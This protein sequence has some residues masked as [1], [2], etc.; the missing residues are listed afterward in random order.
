MVE[1]LPRRL[2]GLNRAVHYLGAFGHIKLWGVAFER[3]TACRGYGASRDE[4]ARAWN[5]ALFNG[6]LD[7]DIA[8]TSALGFDVAQCGEALFQ[9]TPGG[10]GGPCGAQCER[11][12]QNV[13]IVPALRGILALQEDVRVRIDEAG[14]D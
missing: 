4:Q 9:R 5:I 12:I 3:I 1:L 14:Q 8:V 10:N 13:D 7:A 6:H 11:R 2:A